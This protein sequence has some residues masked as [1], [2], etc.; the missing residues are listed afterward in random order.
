MA[1]YRPAD[2]HVLDLDK[3]PT[4]GDPDRVRQLA[5]TLHDFADDVADALRLVKGMASENETLEWAGRTAE[6]FQDEFSDVPKNLKKLKK[7]YDLCGDAL[8]A[9]WPKLERAQALADRALAKGREA[10]ADLSS[11]KSRLSSADSWVTRAAKE[12]DK[13][14]DDPTGSK[15]A[16][17]PDEAK[18]RAATRD[19]QHAES[20]RS[21]AQ[22]DV[23][24]AQSALDAA[25]KMAEDARRMREDAAG[26]AKRRI[27]EASDAGIQNRSWWEDVGD[28]FVD[29]WDTIVAVCKIVVTVVGVVAMIIGGP[30]LGAIVLI[31]ALVVLADTLYKYSKGQASLWDVGFAALDCIPGMKGLTTLGGLAKGLKGGM[32]ALKGL[33]GGLKGMAAGLRGLKSARGL[34]ADGAK[35]AYNRMKSVIRVKGSDPVDM[36]TGAMFLPLTDVTLPG[37]MPLSFSRRVAS[38]YRCGWWFGPTWASTIDQRLETDG[39]GIVF[40]TEDGMLLEYPHPEVSERPVRPTNGP[41]WPLTGLD[42]G[43]YRID[44]PLTGHA[45]H[46]GR[47]SDGVALLS[48]IV[49]RNQ[50]TITFDYDDD[51]TPLAIRHSG[52]Y[53]LKLA[54]S[55]GRVTVLSLAGA[56]EDGTDL[57]VKRYGY[58][59]GN[60][61]ETINSSGLP[62]EFTY[63]SRLRVTSWTDTNRSRYAYVY[64]DRD[65]CVAEGGEA[66]HIS[67]TLDYDG[68]DQAWPGA[69]ITTLT[70]AEGAVT[71]FVVNDNCQVI[72]EIDPLGNVTRTVYDARHHEQSV[73]DALGR[74]ISYTRNELG[75]PLTITYPDAATARFTYDDSHNRPTEVVHADGSVWRREYDER[76]NCTA[77]A[78]PSGNTVRYTHDDFGRLTSVTDP[79]GNETRIE[80]NGAGLT[81][82]LTDPHGTHEW[83]RYDAFGRVRAVGDSTGSEAHLW[84]TVEGKVAR[85]LGPDGA[86]ESW[87]YDGEGNCVRHT[88]ACGGVS[89]YEY[90]HFDMLAARTG[91]D[92]ARFAYEHD[93]SLRLTKVTNPSGLT[94]TYSYD[95][96]GRIV[97]E[98]DFDG[99][100]LRYEHDAVGQVAARVNALGQRIAYERDLLGQVVAKDADG[101]L[102]RYE[103]DAMGRLLTAAGPDSTVGLERD[104]LGR[105]VAERVDDRRLLF[106]YDD[107]G[108]RTRRVT[109]TGAVSEYAYGTHGRRSALTT[110]DHTVR[111]GYDIAGRESSREVD[112][113]LTVHSQWDASGSLIEQTADTPR[114][115]VQSRRFTHRPDGHVVAVDDLLNGPRRIDLDPMGRVTAVNAENWSETYA[116]DAAGNQTAAAWPDS[117]PGAE[118]RGP[119]TYTGTRV[120]R[121]GGV[122]Y[123]YDA[124]GRMVERRRT[125]LSRKPEAWRY[126]WD[127]EDRLTAVVTPD[128]TVWRYRYD[129]FG[130]RS[131]KQ[132]MAADGTSVVEETRFT[133][134]G[135]TLVEQTTIGAGLPHRITVTWD[136]DGLHPVAQTERRADAATQEEIDS[137]FFAI[138]TDLVGTPTELVD[139]QGDVAW[140]SR[141]TLWGNTS[142]PKRS[143]AYTPLRFP[144][145]YHDPETGLH[146]NRHR[147]Y[148]PDSGRYVSPDP[149]GLS[150]APHPTAYVA[151]P[152]AGTDPLGLAPYEPFYRVMSEKEFSRLGPN[153][154]ITPRGENFVTQEPDY[155]T[156]IA[157][158]FARR[159]GRNA[160]KYTHLVRYEMEPGTRDAL[161]AAGRGS[162]DNI[163]AIRESFGLHLDEIGESTEFVHVK[164][165]RGG[166]NF[167][168]REGS[169]DVFNSRIL[170]MTHELL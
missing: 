91:P 65:R 108:R 18:V 2:W 80:A 32:A 157:E 95:P 105:I 88:D 143:T 98:S 116:Y 9:Y 140:R 36:A 42:G 77:V 138:I 159:G 97:S 156:G 103:H 152:W 59:A 136:H 73:T 169:A 133:W 94:W 29:N 90:T 62:F 41:D 8:V 13:Y 118:A 154:E 22:S 38:D 63:D 163:A 120:T 100:V 48:R 168:L 10:Q 61:S 45:R 109:P 141:S 104:R 66:G 127:A 19:A 23:N 124:A 135:D 111:F 26:E 114:G 54:T 85:W 55:E 27:D 129:V 49:D 107:L 126:T 164:L 46:F 123:E 57:V 4:P 28:W 6:V 14:K 92:G 58:T 86:E 40:V 158:R 25:K 102:T 119:R 72:A 112:A 113:S 79:L 142:W 148:D 137:R 44:D 67:I 149:L 11:A 128:G 144:G 110:D 87:E 147:Y 20:A 170:R 78:G 56:A 166:L 125:R 106:A 53:H 155:V 84:W 146:Y 167:G 21:S 161:I 83:R 70:T 33:K 17:K 165:E 71:R 122:R 132:R 37:V 50:N 99:R 139:E 24:G 69:R 7:S 68:T 43:G 51:G 115:T 117:H 39:D 1:G 74:S 5:R 121:A 3:D 16:E 75:Q 162:G 15:S 47:P 160:Q 82:T 76:G 89:S 134:D 64:D 101:A 30:I 93:A 34:I 60:L 12:S 96:A 81:K 131:A 153:G 35:G 151:N 145:Q 52:G 130:R 31:A 150:A